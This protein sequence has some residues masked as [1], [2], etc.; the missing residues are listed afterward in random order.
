MP[1]KVQNTTEEKVINE[2]ETQKVEEGNA[3]QVKP[4]ASTRKTTKNSE[5]KETESKT[6]ASAKKT[7][8][9]KVEEK[10]EEKVV[11][12]KETE[13]SV[14]EEVKNVVEE[15]KSRVDESH[16]DEVDEEIEGLIIVKKKEEIVDKPLEPKQENSKEVKTEITR[17]LD[18]TK[19]KGLTS[20]QVQG[21]LNDGLINFNDSKIAKTT[22]QIIRDNV[23]TFF[24]MLY[25]VITVMLC[26]AQSYANLTFLLVV[27]PNLIISLI[28]EFQAKKTIEKLSLVQATKA[29]VIRDGEKQEVENTEVVLDDVVMFKVGNQI[30]ADCIVLDGTAELNESMITGESDAILKNPGD[31]LYS[32]SFVVSGTVY[33]R[34]EHVG[35]D[36]YIEKLAEEAK[37][38]KGNKSELLRTLN[39]IVKIIGIIIVPLFIIQ[40][41]NSYG[42][43]L[44]W[45]YDQYKKTMET[46]SGS[47]IGMIPSG[48]FLLTSMALAKGVITLGT[49]YNTSVKELYCIE[50]LARVDTLCLDKTGTI[51]DGTMRVVDCI[52]VKNNT[53]YSVREIVGSMMNV[54]E[55][56][57][58]TSDALIRFFSINHVLEPTAILP[59][60]SKR[61]Y[62]AVTFKGAGTFYLGAPEFILIDNY[63]KVK[64]KVDRFAQQGCRV[65]A[66]GHTVTGIKKEGISNAVRPIALI[67]IQD[68]IRDEAYETIEFFRSNG[69]DVKVISG[70]NP[71]TVSEIAHRAGIP[72]YNRYISLEGLSDEEVKEVAFDYTIFGRVTPNQKK[73][74]VEAFKAGK[75]TV[76]MTGDGVNDILAMKE[77]DCS[78]AM[79]SGSE[80]TRNIANIVLMDS[81]FA[82]MPKVVAE[83]RRVIN[84]VQRT[85]TLFLTKTLFVFFLTMFYLIFA[86][87]VGYPFQ[88]SQMILIES[89]I[90]GFPAT[91]ISLQ[92][93][94]EKVKGKFILNVLKAA[95]PGALTILL[96]NVAIWLIA[97]SGNPVISGLDDMNIYTTIVLIVSIFVCLAVL[98]RMCKPFNV[99]RTIIF[100]FSAIVCV[101]FIALSNQ[102]ELFN[103]FLKIV[104]PLDTA[105]ILFL[106]ICLLLINPM[107]NFSQKILSGFSNVKL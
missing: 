34:V 102:V 40:F 104:W 82:S 98:F 52:E 75:R 10:E 86:S 105:Q 47:V 24:N 27:I 20:E 60:S 21:R 50:M 8:K 29:V 22:W 92:P 43:R 9:K 44:E 23:F 85:S 16:K 78:I 76:A 39:M 54:F 57:N 88:P 62:S 80:A 19:E 96:F 70:D 74:L 64:S 48:L 107:L 66:L 2:T 35:K 100:A 36:N 18:V 28:Q 61:K 101:V 106:I 1:K 37:Q 87:E 97:F 83:G 41:F 25:L 94:K 71:L 69:V 95:L 49:K 4:K 7:T 93:N 14:N 30:Y 42:W 56:T 32:G 72:G 81:N 73:A 26:I 91:V 15:E 79:A 11:E 77:A 103:S 65:L 5:T 58:A 46:V 84:N 59:F 33:A 51:T 6:K 99:L 90:I 68:H 13:V 12:V 17:Y 53:D 55:E 3:T 45:D 63:E 89:I 67:V 31:M 38:Q